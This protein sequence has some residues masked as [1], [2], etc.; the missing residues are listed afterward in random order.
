VRVEDKNSLELVD[1]LL[2]SAR[3]RGVSKLLFTYKEMTIEAELL[4][5]PATPLKRDLGKETKER[6]D[7]LTFSS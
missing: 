5:E 4:P 3:A 2:D 6:E 7:T 1:Q